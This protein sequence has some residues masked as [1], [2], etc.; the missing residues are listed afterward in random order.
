MESLEIA[1]PPAGHG[2]AQD[3][4]W[5]IVHHRGVWRQVRLHDYPEVFRVQGL[6]EKWVYDVLGCQSPQKIAAL[7]QGALREQGVDPGSL[8]VLDLGA[9]NGCVA[10]ALREIGIGE[11][12]GVDLH[13]EAAMAAERDRPGLYQDYVVGDLTDLPASEESKLTENTFHAMASVAAL[14][15]GDI[16]PQVFARAYNETEDGGWIA[17]TIKRDFLLARDDSGFFGLIR[18]MIDEGVLELT[19]RQTYVHRR[20]T[21]GD[22]L[23]Y[24]AVIGRKLGAI[25]EPWLIG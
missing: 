5:A 12:V 15:F 10:E 8:R 20:S 24:V 22:P 7:L 1:L 6:Y 16:P 25:P 4:E 13:P 9:G 19:S 18:R 21:D 14:G 11:F 23:E 17:F 2:L 3:E